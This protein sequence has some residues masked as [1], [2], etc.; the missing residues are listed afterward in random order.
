MLYVSIGI[1]VIACVVGS[2]VGVLDFR[3]SEKK[4]KAEEK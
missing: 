3:K 1:V 4:K 2:L